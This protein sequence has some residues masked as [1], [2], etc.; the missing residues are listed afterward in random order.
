MQVI[1]FFGKRIGD[2]K[3]YYC[4]NLID[5]VN[6]DAFKVTVSNLTHPI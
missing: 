1:K 4:C 2:V 3:A 6:S 5:A